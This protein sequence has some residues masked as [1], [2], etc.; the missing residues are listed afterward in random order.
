MH[1]NLN[2]QNIQRSKDMEAK[3]KA[4]NYLMIAV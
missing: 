3:M 2:N 4:P 1:K